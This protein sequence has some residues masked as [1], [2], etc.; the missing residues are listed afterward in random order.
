M[1]NPSLNVNMLADSLYTSRSKL[2]REWKKVSEISIT[3]FIKSI[4]FEEAIS[5][6]KEQGFSIH[7]AARATGFSNTKY[8][9]TSFKKEFGYSPSEIKT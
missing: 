1:A 5:L 9:S 7:E 6:I 3:D 4:R 8:F 2:Y